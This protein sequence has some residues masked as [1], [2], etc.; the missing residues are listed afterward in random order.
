MVLF[1]QTPQSWLSKW[2]GPEDPMQY[3][4]SLVARAMAL[5]SWV[6]KVERNSLLNEPLLLNELFHPDTFLNA[7][8][9]Q[10]AR[11]VQVLPALSASTPISTICTYANL[12][13]KPI[14]ADVCV[15]FRN[16]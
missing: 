8:R 14:F 5:Q 1:W 12:V 4:R 16:T 3:L 6:E 7:L 2:D 15:P 10:T 9:Q 13:H 11:L